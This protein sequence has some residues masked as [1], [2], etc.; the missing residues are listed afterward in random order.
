MLVSI[1]V[2]AI[3]VAIGVPVFSSALK[4]SRQ[5]RSIS[6]LRAIGQAIHLYAADNGGAFPLMSGASG[7]S[8][9]GP[10]W[11]TETLSAYVGPKN[12]GNWVFRDPQLSENHCRLGDYA[13]NSDVL[14]NAVPGFSSQPIPLRV[15]GLEGRASKVIMVVA[16]EDGG[17][18]VP[19]GAWFLDA[20]AV[21]FNPQCPYYR[22]SDRGTGK[23]LAVFADGH[24]EAIAKSDLFENVR[25]Y[26]LVNE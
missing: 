5:A 13:A 1:V 23:I 9:S 25:K 21:A 14:R 4:S 16:G 18:S 3:I 22:P 17:S 11:S 7:G 26:F 24:T 15:A 10:I 12:N 2:I 20:F 19:S 6:N 8:L